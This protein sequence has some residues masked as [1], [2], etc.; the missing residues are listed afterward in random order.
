MRNEAAM[1]RE[2]RENEERRKATEAAGIV[3]DGVNRHSFSADQLA[4]AFLNHHRTLQQGFTRVVL[5][6][7]QKQAEMY[8]KGY[9]D[10]RNEDTCKW[11]KKLKDAGL[12]DN[13]GFRYV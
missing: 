8:E 11:A 1:I 10:L 5:A 9:Y 13:V 7:L 3:M 6:Y 4:E 12:L 2:A